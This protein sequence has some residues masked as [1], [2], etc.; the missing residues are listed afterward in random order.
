MKNYYTKIE[1]FTSQSYFKGLSFNEELLKESL[2]I[3]G[4]YNIH[5]LRNKSKILRKLVEYNVHDWIDRINLSKNHKIGSLD[6]FKILYGDNIGKILYDKSNI[7]R[8]NKIK[9]IYFE[10]ST[11]FLTQKPFK[12]FSENLNENSKLQIENIIINY[13]KLYLLNSKKEMISNL[14]RYNVDGDWLVRLKESEKFKKASCFLDA[15]VIRYGE[16]IGKQL[17]NENVKKVITNRENYTEE[18]W[19][20]LCESKKSN[21]GLI[22]YIR[23]YGEEVGTQKW[24]V[25]FKKWRIGIDK[26]KKEGWKNGR[27]LVEYQERCGIKEGYEKW[28]K[29]YDKRNYT[30]SLNGFVDRF[31]KKEGREKYHK[32]IEKMVENCRCDNPY[33]KISQ[34]LFDEIYKRLEKNKQNN[35]KYYTLNGEQSFYAD[36]EFNLNL[37]YVDFKCGNVII[38]FDGTYWHSTPLIKNKDTRRTL[39]LES[40]SYKVLRI[41]EQEYNK[42][43]QKI[44]DKCLQ[45]INENYEKTNS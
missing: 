4:K 22:G 20:N 31:G 39:F 3:I 42:D 16:I 15:N 6:Y 24:N 35:V 8:K 5:Q 17:Y 45:F 14:L 27:S 30:L 37:I 18:E 44:V 23:K 26:K 40:K 41:K 19:K 34:E 43:K 7:K 29:S 12:I 38:E 1:Q 21:L 36:G 33:S 11:Q 32:H 25:Y 9:Q 28:R 13:P 10:T 2:E